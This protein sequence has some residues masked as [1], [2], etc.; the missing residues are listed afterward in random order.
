ESIIERQRR[1]FP[2]PECKEAPVPTCEHPCCSL[3]RRSRALR[4]SSG[5]AVPGMAGRCAASHRHSKAAG[6]G[7]ARRCCDCDTEHDAG[8][9]GGGQRVP[10]WGL[11]RGLRQSRKLATGPLPSRADGLRADE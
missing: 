1:H 2:S 9:Q 4:R 8:A 7:Q 5:E 6:K 10:L 11:S 3:R